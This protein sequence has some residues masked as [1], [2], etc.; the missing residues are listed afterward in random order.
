MEFLE[1]KFNNLSVSTRT[2]SYNLVALLR[3]IAVII[4]QPVVRDALKQCAV[5]RFFKRAYIRQKFILN[6][7]VTLQSTTVHGNRLA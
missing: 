4:R 1:V 5:N 2:E 3:L 7:T 6:R